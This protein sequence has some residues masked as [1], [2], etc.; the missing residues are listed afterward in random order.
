MSEDIE[1]VK[2][3]IAARDRLVEERRALAVAIALGYRRRRTDD[4]QTREMREAFV[5]IQDT[6]DAIDRA[7]EDEHRNGNKEP[8]LAP[9][10]K[11]TAN[12]AGYDHSVPD[13]CADSIP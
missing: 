12:C 6:I 11:A 10:A 4:G 8:G 13:Q 3:L 2:T 7:I 5:G 9:P 1:A